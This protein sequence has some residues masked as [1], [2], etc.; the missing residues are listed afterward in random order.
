MRLAIALTLGISTVF[1][2]LM[3]FYAARLCWLLMPPLLLMLA[4]DMKALRL[5][6]KAPDRWRFKAVVLA[7]VTVYVLQLVLREGPYS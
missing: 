5:T 2:A 4:F 7:G 6:L 1:L 3:G